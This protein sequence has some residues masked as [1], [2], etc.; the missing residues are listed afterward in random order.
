MEHDLLFTIIIDENWKEI[1]ANG[2]FSPN[3]VEELGYIKCIDEKHIEDYINSEAFTDKNLLLVVI[4]PL[5]IKESI[6]NDR[7][8]ELK[9]IKIQG[10]LS[11]DA[12]IDK[13]PLEKDKNGK[14]SLNIKHFD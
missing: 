13:I 2:N 7:E 9:I 12:V 1:T 11:L 5:R 8:G 10:N 14:Y 6:K 3:S 4:D